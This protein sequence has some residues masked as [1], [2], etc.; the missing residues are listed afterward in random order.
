VPLTYF[1][2]FAPQPEVSWRGTYHL[3]DSQIRESWP[4]LPTVQE[5]MNRTS[6]TY[7][8]MKGWIILPNSTANKIYIQSPPRY[9]DNCS[10]TT[11]IENSTEVNCP[12]SMGLIPRV[13]RIYLQLDNTT[14]IIIPQTD[15]VNTANPPK[16]PEDFDGFLDT[17]M[18][19]AYGYAAVAVISVS[20]VAGI[21]II[22]LL[23][24]KNKPQPSA[25]EET[26]P[27]FSN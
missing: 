2:L 18:P 27:N 20:I 3:S 15:L 5:L 1:T 12:S 14:W 16:L 24:Q 17:D 6:R 8:D 19:A 26:L 25:P 7:L 23:R 10:L 21:T 11:V 4:N 9:W 13:Y 22:A